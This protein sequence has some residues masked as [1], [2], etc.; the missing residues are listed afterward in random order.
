MDWSAAE[1][2]SGTSARAPRSA[3]DD[4]SAAV[5]AARGRPHE[6][7]EDVPGLRSLV[8]AGAGELLRPR[9]E[10]DA[11]GAERVVERPF[12]ARV[13]ARE[14]VLR[15]EGLAQGGGPGDGP[16]SSV[17]DRERNDDA[18]RKNRDGEQCRHHGA[19]TAR[20]ARPQRRSAPTSEPVNA[21]RE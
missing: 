2:P 8:R 14:D 3:R 12:R 15:A 7:D 10:D 1:S 13:L 16:L 17:K 9:L 4:A 5:S 11:Q 19:R 20:R 21:P 6:H 18:D